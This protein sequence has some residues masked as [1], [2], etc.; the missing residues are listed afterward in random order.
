M[1]TKQHY[2][3]IAKAIYESTYHVSVE[4]GT[5]SVIDRG[6]FLTALCDIFERD[7]PRFDAYEFID[8][9]MG[10]KS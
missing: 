6:T 2:E 3:E 8:A 10:V 9:C 7:N 1:F 5:Y 4:P